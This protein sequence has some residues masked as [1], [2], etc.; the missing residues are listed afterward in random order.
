MMHECPCT[1]SWIRSQIG[2]ARIIVKGISEIPVSCHNLSL[3]LN[4]QMDIFD[5]V[6][7]LWTL[8]S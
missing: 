3:K 2:L 8:L 5:I 6:V 1:T 7:W 4:D